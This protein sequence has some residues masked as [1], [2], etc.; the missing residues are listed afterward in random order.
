VGT[1]YYFQTKQAVPWTPMPTSHASNN[2]SFVRNGIDKS[3]QK[4]LIGIDKPTKIFKMLW[5]VPP[6]WLSEQKTHIIDYC[7]FKNCQISFNNNDR[8]Y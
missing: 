7:E 1:H 3:P 6:T 8:Y 4:P 2:K 5:F